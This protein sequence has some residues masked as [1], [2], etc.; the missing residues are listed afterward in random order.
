MQLREFLKENQQLFDSFNI[1]YITSNPYQSSKN[2]SYEYL[3]LQT[4]E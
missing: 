3:A 4:K 1:A 2:L